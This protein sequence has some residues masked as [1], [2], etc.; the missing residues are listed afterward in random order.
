MGECKPKCGQ[1]FLLKI[2]PKF[3][4][5]FCMIFLNFLLLATYFKSTIWTSHH[6]PMGSLVQEGSGST[7]V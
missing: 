5:D 3:M 1:I 7:C 6:I 2:T 4:I